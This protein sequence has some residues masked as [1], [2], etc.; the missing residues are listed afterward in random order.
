MLLPPMREN[1]V[2]VVL[3]IAKDTT[4]LEEAMRSLLKRY[5]RTSEV[6]S[7]R[8]KVRV[9]RA[10]SQHEKFLLNV[11]VYATIKEHLLQDWKVANV[12]LCQNGRQ[13]VP[14]KL[15]FHMDFT[16]TVGSLTSPLSSP[17][18]ENCTPRLSSWIRSLT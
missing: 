17:N 7:A 4:N 16:G 3:E 2:G 18:P 11:Q 8:A 9:G 5:A 13:L 15:G 6:E 1:F 12:F 14:I 10:Y